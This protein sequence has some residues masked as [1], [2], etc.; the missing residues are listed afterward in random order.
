M[1]ER[2]PLQI[3]AFQATHLVTLTLRFNPSSQ[4]P[5]SSRFLIASYTRSPSQTHSLVSSPSIDRFCASR[6]RSKCF[7]SPLCSKSSSYNNSMAV[8]VVPIESALF[9]SKTQSSWRT[10]VDKNAALSRFEMGEACFIS[11]KQRTPDWRY[12]MH[13]A[14][15]E[16]YKPVCKTSFHPNANR[17]GL[18]ILLDL[19]SP[20][21]FLPSSVLGACLTQTIA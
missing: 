2:A 13:T 4:H 17:P 9:R 5:S 8:Q 21:F 19:A 10:K 11:P 14:L 12:R 15:L 1:P 6:R 18:A 7:L 3:P 20:L 16:S